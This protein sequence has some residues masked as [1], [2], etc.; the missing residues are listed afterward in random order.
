MPDTT[1][2]TDL[3][4]LGMM[5]E[6]VEALENVRLLISGPDKGEVCVGILDAVEMYNAALNSVCRLA[7]ELKAHVE[8]HEGQSKLD[9]EWINGLKAQ[10]AAVTGERDF[11]GEKYRLSAWCVAE[12]WGLT[13]YED[14]TGE[15]WPESEDSFL[16]AA[17]T[18]Y[19]ETGERLP[20]LAARY[21]AQKEAGDE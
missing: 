6:E 9:N 20:I 13:E 2:L 11:I 19:E 7:A 16:S 3:R 15:D 12:G 10:L 21:R 18:A 4:R 17:L 5:T 8:W 14:A 1:P